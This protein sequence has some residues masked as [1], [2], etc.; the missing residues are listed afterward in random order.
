M[1]RPLVL[2]SA[3]LLVALV[4]CDDDDARSID[5]RSQ[6]VRLAA[7]DAVVMTDPSYSPGIGDSW[8]VVTSPDPRVAKIAERIGGCDEP[9]C[10]GRLDETITAVGAGDTTVVLQYCY[11]SA[12][13][14]CEPRP[15]EAVRPPV[16]VRIEVD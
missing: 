14:N 11:R 4:G 3:L 7:G 8:T 2:L 15:G 16:T 12:P 1:A 9:G 10:T 5:F 6:T 13:P